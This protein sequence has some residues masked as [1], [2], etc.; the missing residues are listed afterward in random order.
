MSA[1]D[2]TKPRSKVVRQFVAKYMTQITTLDDQ[3]KEVHDKRQE[4]TET[5]ITEL[6]TEAFKNKDLKR[7]YDDVVRE[8]DKLKVELNSAKR[9]KTERDELARELEIF[10]RCTNEIV[11]NIEKAR[12]DADSADIV[13]VEPIAHEV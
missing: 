6:A 13:L 8:R 1:Q 9:Y 5:I 3:A 11:A 10:K 7:K 12:Q 4:V 2:S